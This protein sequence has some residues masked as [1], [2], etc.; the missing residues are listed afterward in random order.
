MM[1][2]PGCG[3]SKYIKSSFLSKTDVIIDS[4]RLKTEKEIK[5]AFLIALQNEGNYNIIL[6]GSHL[7][8]IKRAVYIHIAKQY[9]N[10]IILTHIKTYSERIIEPTHEL[11]IYYENYDE[12]NINEGFTNII[13]I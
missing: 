10:D 6:D 11:N 1:G 3:K 7:S 9:T 12:P 2:Y 5:N 8:I 13:T 4:D